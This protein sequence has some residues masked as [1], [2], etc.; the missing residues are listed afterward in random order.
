MLDSTNPPTHI[1]RWYK[2]V[3]LL[4]FAILTCT[5]SAQTRLSVSIG[6]NFFTQHFQ[7][8]FY[9]PKFGSTIYTTDGS[10]KTKSMGTF[11][12][13]D[14]YARTRINNGLYWVTGLNIFQ[15]GYSNFVDVRYSELKTT[16]LGIPLMV[17]VNYLNMWYIDIGMLARTPLSATLTE[18]YQP[19]GGP[20]QNQRSDIKRY[21]NGLSLGFHAES[22]IVIKR[23][24]IT[25]YW[26]F[27]KE[28]VDPDFEN[29]WPLAGR[30]LFIRDFSPKYSYQFM[31]VK[32]GI[33][34]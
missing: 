19:T 29:A 9:T 15:T 16:Y 6:S 26:T 33:R 12:T 8:G 34:L 27:G 25:W 11:L 21:L 17:R 3:F 30:S 20:Q 24:L 14:A 28:R 23:L 10:Y 22:S 13:V 32:L 4:T 5:L 2:F 7:Q 1:D 31:G 18:M